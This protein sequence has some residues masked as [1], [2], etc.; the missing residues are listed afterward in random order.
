MSA[1]APCAVTVTDTPTLDS[2]ANNDVLPFE[3]LTFDFSSRMEAPATLELAGLRDQE[4]SLS[5]LSIQRMHSRSSLANLRAPPR[6]VVAAEL[7]ELLAGRKRHASCAVVDAT[8]G[9]ARDLPSLLSLSEVCGVRI[10][11]SA[12]MTADEASALHRTDADEAA[13]ALEA[14][15]NEIVSQLTKGVEV[16][17][18]PADASAASAATLVRC[19]M[20]VAGD[21]ALLPPGSQPREAV[22]HV[23]GRAQMRTGAPLLFALPARAAG[24]GGQS[25]LTAVRE[26]VAEHGA[27]ATGIVI[28][29]AQNLLVQT[30]HGRGGKLLPT[31]STPNTSMAT[32]RELLGTGACLCFDGFGAEWTVPGYGGEA[33]DEAI[34]DTT[35]GGGSARGNRGFELCGPLALRPPTDDAV[36]R[37]VAA[38]VEEGFAS[39]LILSQG[40]WTRLQYTS[41]GGCGLGHLRRCVCPLL[42]RA[43]VTSKET[44]RALTAGNAAR[45]LAWWRPAEKPPRLV[46]LWECHACH[47]SFEE[48]AN[49]A[50]ALETDHVYYEKKDMRYCSMPCLSAHRKANFVLPFKCPPPPE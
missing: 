35:D 22:L 40:T 6:D 38:L 14:A 31:H 39:Q 24:D 37:C 49:P 20:L 41:Y 45:L 9:A 13:E 32:I 47:R 23:M 44:L 4:L 21:A 50:E 46:K 48:A 12:G 10:I 19:G 17:Y 36:A 8:I 26:L 30:E 33:Y 3:H 43:G 15:C 42:A 28:G 29:H 27:S 34:M 5:R 7:V 25:A 1:E 16:N 18:R 11:A 2:F